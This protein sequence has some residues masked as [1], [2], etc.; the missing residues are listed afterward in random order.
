M[1][2]VHMDIVPYL[3]KEAKETIDNTDCLWLKLYIE[4]FETVWNKPIE[5]KYAVE[6]QNS[7]ECNGVEK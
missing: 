2:Y 5:Y 6:K 7:S 3:E 1:I 4:P